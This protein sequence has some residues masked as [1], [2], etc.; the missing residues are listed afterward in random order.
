[1]IQFSLVYLLFLVV[2]I[3]FFIASI[4]LGN[5]S[6][7]LINKEKFDYRNM[8][9]Y[10]QIENA[11]STKLRLP[12]QISLWIYLASCAGPFSLILTFV[13]SLGNLTAVMLIASIVEI[14]GALA[15]LT[16]TM[17]PA[18]F[19]RQ[20]TLIDTI[21]FIATF[22]VAALAAVISF[23][24][25]ISATNKVYYG[26]CGGFAVIFALTSAILIINPRLRNW[27]KLETKTNEDGTKEL[28]RP[29]YF[30]LAY[31]EWLFVLLFE[32]STIA[33]FLSILLVA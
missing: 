14:I 33:L 28:V 15:L 2:N 10:E 19:I 6:Y 21:F 3:L 12:Y 20:H 16:I 17:L 24:T 29:K 13:Y 11:T 23:T 8:F 30:A 5:I 22:L 31:T 7:R 25:M 1:M 18:K 9:L 27:A 32:L 26:I 4:Y